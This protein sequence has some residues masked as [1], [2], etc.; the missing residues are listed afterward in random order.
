MSWNYKSDTEE[1]VL[2]K[3]EEIIPSPEEEII[4]PSE[5]SSSFVAVVG[6]SF[7]RP[8]VRIEAGED[9]PKRLLDGLSEDAL[10]WLLNKRKAIKKYRGI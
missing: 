9:V 4:I 8:R 7:D 2:D 1:E 3:E 6:V 10:D 5:D